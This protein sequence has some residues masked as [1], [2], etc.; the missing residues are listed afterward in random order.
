[1]GVRKAESMGQRAES[2]GHGA[3]QIESIELRHPELVS[4]SAS[5]RESQNLEFET[6]NLEFKTIGYV[7]GPGYRKEKR[8]ENET[9][10]YCR[11]RASFSAVALSDFAG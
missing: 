11:W 10:L 6:W 7:N 5:I 4:G 9:P 8:V 1:L 2:V 3:M